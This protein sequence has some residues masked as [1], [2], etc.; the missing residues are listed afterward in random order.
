M[1]EREEEEREVESDIPI[2]DTIKYNNISCFVLLTQMQKILSKIF[3]FGLVN[4]FIVLH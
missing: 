2:C 1:N 4:I 3:R